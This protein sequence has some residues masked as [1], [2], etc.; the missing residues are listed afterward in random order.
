MLKFDTRSITDIL[1]Y[2]NGEDK[3]ECWVIAAGSDS[4][5]RVFS[6]KDM[7]ILYSIK[8]IFGNPISMDISAD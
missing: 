6:L 4:F 8:G 2:R 1:T 5:V 7:K 3:K